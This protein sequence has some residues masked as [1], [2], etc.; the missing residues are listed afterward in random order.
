MPKI[1]SLDSIKKKWGE[2]TPQRAGQY[3]DGVT[4]P[5][6]DWKT[7][8]VAAA[9]NYK[10]AMTISLTQ[11]RFL[12]GVNKVNTEKWKSKAILKGASRFSEGVSL[13][14]E[15]YGTGFAP[16]RDVIA[17]TTLPP[18]FPKGDPRNIERVRVMAEALRK[19]KLG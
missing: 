16:Y 7:N 13:G 17:N 19:A 5:K 3:V 6:A 4:D 8:T 15:D 14:V 9:A 18:R 11:D 12:K 2:V 1:R 10:A